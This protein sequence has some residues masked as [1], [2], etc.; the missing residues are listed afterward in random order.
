[1]RANIGS[2]WT[3]FDFWTGYDRDATKELGVNES[4]RII[5][6]IAL[7]SVAEIERKNIGSVERARSRKPPYAPH[8]N[9]GW[10]LPTSDDRGWLGGRT[11]KTRIKF[12]LK[13]PRL[14]KSI[15]AIVSRCHRL[16]PP[17]FE[18]QLIRDYES[19]HY[20]CQDPTDNSTPNP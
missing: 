14:L 8:T 5:T 4:K 1:M 9:R 11:R 3:T 7:V 12:V 6:N 19:K 15:K 20:T 17:R 2:P 10:N 13:A 18:P 16:Q